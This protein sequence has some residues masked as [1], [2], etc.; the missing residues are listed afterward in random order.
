MAHGL[1]FQGEELVSG[2]P[3][4]GRLAWLIICLVVLPGDVHVSQPEWTPEWKVRGG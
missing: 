1:R 2:L 3:L 4:A